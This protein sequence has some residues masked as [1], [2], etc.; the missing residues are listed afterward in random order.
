ML[1]RI[2]DFTALIATVAFAIVPAIR[3]TNHGIR[4]VPQELIEA[5]T[6]SGCT[7]RQLF[8]RV[9]LPVAVPEIMLGINQ[10]ILLA[11]SMIIICA[12]IG[13]RDLGQEVFKALVQGRYRQGPRGRPGDRLHRHHRRPADHRLG[14]SAQGGGAIFFLTDY[15]TVFSTIVVVIGWPSGK[16]MYFNE[17]DSRQRRQLID[18]QQAFEAW[19]SASPDMAHRFAGSMRWAQRQGNEYLLRK[20]RSVEHSLGPRGSDTIAMQDA[21]QSGRQATKERLA[22]LAEQLDRLAPIN[23]AMGLGR[24]PVAAGRVLRTWMSMVFWAAISL[25]WE[26]MH[27]MPMRCWPAFNSKAG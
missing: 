17:L 1:F 8:W 4:Q 22:G 2:G 5:G 7:K 13:T 27:S 15:F 3:Y 24:V 11:L 23:R 14:G 20:V 10:T 16:A 25:S 21:F 6:V 9:Q 18:T 19:R 26:R 12:M